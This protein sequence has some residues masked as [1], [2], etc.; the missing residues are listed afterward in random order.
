MAAHGG[1]DTV[2]RELAQP[3]RVFTPPSPMSVTF[4]N[5]YVLLGAQQIQV[6]G[7]AFDSAEKSAPQ[8]NP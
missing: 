7:V 6:H 8:Q 1:P 4:T 3:L 2:L 5:C